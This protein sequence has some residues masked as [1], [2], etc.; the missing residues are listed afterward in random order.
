MRFAGQQSA[1]P[2]YQSQ[3]ASCRFKF[4]WAT[5]LS[6]QRI[7]AYVLWSG[8]IFSIVLTVWRTAHLVHAAQL[9]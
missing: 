3:F 4:G 5:L 7:L 1:S 9:K 8:L 6:M 2:V